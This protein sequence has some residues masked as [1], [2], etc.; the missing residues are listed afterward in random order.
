MFLMSDFENSGLKALRFFPLRCSQIDL[1]D[2][3]EESIRDKTNQ[4]T[5][6][7]RW[8]SIFQEVHV[9][10]GGADRN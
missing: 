1:T 10:V 9:G 7:W 5:W 8:K 2:L 3:P 6:K 4:L